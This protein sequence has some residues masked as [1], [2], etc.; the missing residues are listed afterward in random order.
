MGNLP[1]LLDKPD[2]KNFDFRW[3]EGENLFKYYESPRG[4][5]RGFCSDCRSPIVNRAEPNWKCWPI[6]P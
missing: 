2:A 5:L 6:S 4:Y 3:L 1:V